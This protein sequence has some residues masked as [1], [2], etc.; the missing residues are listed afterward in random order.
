MLE[1]HTI[2]VDGGQTQDDVK[3]LALILT[4]WTVLGP[5]VKSGRPGDTAFI[6]NRHEPGDFTLLGK[7][8]PDGGP[9][10]AETALLHLARHPATAHFVAGK[11]ARHFIS[12]EVPP[13]LVDRLADTFVETDGDLA[14]LSVTLLDS[15]EAW[16]T[17]YRKLRS[18]YEFL[19]AAHRL[20]GLQPRRVGLVLTSLRGMGQQVW[21]PEGPDG[22]PDSDLYWG[23]GQG[24]RSRLAV[25]VKLAERSRA[26]PEALIDAAFGEDVSGDTR[27]TIMKAGDRQ[28]ATTLL[29]MSPEFQ[30]R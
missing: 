29:L 10:Q 24:L 13:A 20:C 14:A 16:D 25:A 3:A 17:Q 21:A 6:M 1:L 28:Q 15:P 8:Y 5:N 2:G 26:E 18:P 9:E 27:G 7:V 22:F 23:S 30:W 19:L 4:G 11:L 12:D